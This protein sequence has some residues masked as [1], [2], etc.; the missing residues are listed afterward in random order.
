MGKNTMAITNL[1][2][3][4][5]NDYARY[6]SFEKSLKQI[7][8][9]WVL[10]SHSLKLKTILQ[11]YLYYTEQHL[12]QLE[13]VSN[14][15]ISHYLINRDRT[16]DYRISSINKRLAS[17]TDPEVRDACLL[18]AVQELNHQKISM[19]GTAASFS[20]MLGDKKAAKIFY[21]AEV[22]EKQIDKRLSDL[23]EQEINLRARTP[24]ALG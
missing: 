20:N 15:I 9:N 3:L 4:L 24:L 18:A 22:S 11:R 12:N 23:A 6:F 16:I 1:H 17:C 10:L 7:L 21:A 19:Y 14:E 2:D 5:I 8:P 13:S